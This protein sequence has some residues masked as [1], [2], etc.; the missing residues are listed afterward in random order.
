MDTGNDPW[1]WAHDLSLFFSNNS[2]NNDN[3]NTI[4]H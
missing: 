1:E 2:N 3:D 4:K